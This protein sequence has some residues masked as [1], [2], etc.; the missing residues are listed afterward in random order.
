MTSSLPAGYIDTTAAVERIV[1]NA[2]NGNLYSNWPADA[3][4]KLCGELIPKGHVRPLMLTADGFSERRTLPNSQVSRTNILGSKRFLDTSQA[5]G[6]TT[7]STSMAAFIASLGRFFSKA[8]LR[9]HLAWPRNP[10]RRRPVT[11]P[12]VT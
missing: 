2:R 4:R 8:R 3:W 9:R 7:F 5:I 1:R 11:K 6:Y 12:R 10:E